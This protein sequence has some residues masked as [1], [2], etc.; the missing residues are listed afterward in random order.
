MRIDLE[1][2]FII[3]SHLEQIEFALSVAPAWNLREFD[4]RE[5][6]STKEHYRDY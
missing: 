3:R 2:H 4:E 1:K 5:T 6:Q